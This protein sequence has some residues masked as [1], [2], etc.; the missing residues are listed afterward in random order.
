MQS[1]KLMVKCMM[2]SPPGLDQRD[3]DFD[4]WARQAWPKLSDD[5]LAAHGR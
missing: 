5:L 4:D 2:V 3:R 1:R